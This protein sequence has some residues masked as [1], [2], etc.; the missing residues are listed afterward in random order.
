MG[1]YRTCKEKILKQIDDL[2][3]GN[4]EKE[5]AIKRLEE[6]IRNLKADKTQN[7]D[8]LKEKAEESVQESEDIV[9]ETLITSKK[10]KWAMKD[11]TFAEC[12]IEKYK[13]NMELLC[14]LV[15]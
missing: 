7:T 9:F 14:R 3:Q 6:D 2:K 8:N 11:K 13:V 4:N 10:N 5:S 15:W 12:I 1:L